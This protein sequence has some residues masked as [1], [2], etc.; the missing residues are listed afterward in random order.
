MNILKSFK[1]MGAMITAAPDMIDS[2]NQMAAQ[3]RQ[4]QASATAASTPVAVAAAP[5]N[6][7]PIAGVDITLYVTISKGV[8]VYNY[9]AA[10]LP[11]IAAAHGVTAADWQLAQ[12]GWGA[13]LKSDAGVASTF[14]SLYT[15]N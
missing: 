13:R 2:A 11:S 3:A 10:M 6:L 12:D 1:D 14:N 9:D 4:M 7:T 15:A 8:A 5:E